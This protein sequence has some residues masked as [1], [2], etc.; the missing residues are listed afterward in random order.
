MAEDRS[1]W[2]LVFVDRI[3]PSPFFVA[4]GRRNR[5][6]SPVQPCRSL[7]RVAESWAGRRQ[8]LGRQWPQSHPVLP[9]VS[10]TCLKKNRRSAV[11]GPEKMR[12]ENSQSMCDA[13]TSILVFLQRGH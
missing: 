11:R 3:L 9:D 1:Q 4:V 5:H 6:S 13:S 10:A 12:M 7:G 8:L 2:E